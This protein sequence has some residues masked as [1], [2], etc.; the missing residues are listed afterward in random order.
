MRG[1]MNGADG[2]LQGTHVVLTA[3]SG[4]TEPT[5]SLILT[6]DA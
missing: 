3:A 2:F 1:G 5:V 6:D 4:R